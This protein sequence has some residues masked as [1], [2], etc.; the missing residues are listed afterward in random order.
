[1]EANIERHFHKPVAQERHL[2]ND[3][4]D[5]VR[6]DKGDPVARFGA[7]SRQRPG[8]PGCLQLQFGEGNG[9]VVVDIGG[10]VWNPRQRV[11]E[12]SRETDAGRGVHV[13]RP[14]RCLP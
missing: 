5:G 11:V 12:Y 3:K 4:R 1:M 7:G 9:A 6:Q 13:R 2:D 8:H 10:L 14:Q